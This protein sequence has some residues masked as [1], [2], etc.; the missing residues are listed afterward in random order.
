MRISS[1]RLFSAGPDGGW[2]MDEAEHREQF[3]TGHYGFNCLLESVFERHFGVAAA[4]AAGPSQCRES[5]PTFPRAGEAPRPE[6][7]SRTR[8]RRALA[9]GKATS[10][11]SRACQVI[12]LAHLQRG[13]LGESSVSRSPGSMLDGPAEGIRGGR[14]RWWGW[15]L[16]A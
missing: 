16:S 4:L 11:A 6:S 5:N 8:P 10:R 15:Q 12:V 1:L 14:A 9:L 2:S 3:D 7:R 13:G